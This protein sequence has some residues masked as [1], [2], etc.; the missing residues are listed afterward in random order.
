M[1]D[2]LELKKELARIKQRLIDIEKAVFPKTKSREIKSMKKNDEEPASIMDHLLLLKNQGFFDTPRS[3]KDIVQK[4]AS[5][6]KFYEP[7]SLD[8]PLNRA[9]TSKKL[10]RISKNGLYLYVSR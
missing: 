10:G 4:L 2:D 5:M 3:R 1:T 7:T 8:S 9:F 6:K